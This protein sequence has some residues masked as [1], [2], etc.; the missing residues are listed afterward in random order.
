VGLKRKIRVG[1][2]DDSALVRTII[3]DI[4]KTDD[5]FEI[6]GTGRNGVECLK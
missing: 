6:V 5:R 3:S 4:L 1:V 2:I